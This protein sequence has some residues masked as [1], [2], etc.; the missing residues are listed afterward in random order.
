MIG[1]IQGMIH[2]YR[3]YRLVK[4]VDKEN[5]ILADKALVEIFA[6]NN[7]VV[8]D[9]SLVEV[10]YA[11]AAFGEMNVAFKKVGMSQAM[12]II[13]SSIRNKYLEQETNKHGRKVLRVDHVKGRN[14]IDGI[15]YLPLGLWK[16]WYKEHGW[17]IV[18]LVGVYGAVLGGVTR[19][20]WHLV[21]KYLQ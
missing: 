6:G 18:V 13:G 5:Q 11:S 1:I 16:A 10:P 14:L 7:E 12:T 8:D 19:V 9:F 4:F 20:I 3:M 15:P 21:Q 17:L 2:I